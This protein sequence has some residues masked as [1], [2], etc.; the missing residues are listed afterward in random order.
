M[1]LKDSLKHFKDADGYSVIVTKEDL[2]NNMDSLADAI[3]ETPFDKDDTQIY[4]KEISLGFV[5]GAKSI[6]LENSDDGDN[7]IFFDK[8]KKAFRGGY[9]S[10]DKW[11][12]R[13]YF[14]FAYG[15]DVDASE[16]SV[17]FGDNVKA[18]AKFSTIFGQGI[19][20]SQPYSQKRGLKQ[21]VSSAANRHFNNLKTT[22]DTKT[23][24]NQDIIL[25]PS[26]LFYIL[27][28]S[29]NIQDDY[30]TKWIF[31]RN[32]IVTIDND[33]S[34]TIVSDKNVDIAKDD[35]DW[36]FDI[37]KTDGDDDNPP[38]LTL[39]ATGKADTNI[40]WSVEVEIREVSI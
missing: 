7:K 18:I 6:N 26:S 38:I 8:E 31:E 15:N 36:A 13:D 30:S 29:T 33:K 37:E 25:S 5:I 4:P 20:N 1:A 24:F 21:D 32:L 27:I 2:D 17:A 9:V 28:H 22:D 23:S 12:N 16:N 3:D 14:S 35:D 39:K 11:D 19:E 40:A 34:V 10:N